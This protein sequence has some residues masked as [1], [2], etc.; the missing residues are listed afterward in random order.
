MK[1]PPLLFN[2]YDIFAIIE[3]QKKALNKAIAGAPAPASGTPDDD[4]VN[5]FV[6]Q[7]TIAVPTL[8]PDQ[9]SLEQ[10]EVDVD[11][12]RD[13][14]RYFSDPSRPFYVKG[15][16][17]SVHVPFT[18]EEALFDTRPSTFSLSP[19]RGEVQDGELILTYIFPNDSPPPNLR[20]QMDADLAGVNKY[21]D[22][23]RNSASTLEAELVPIARA[24]WQKRKGE[25]STRDNVIAKLGVPARRVDAPNQT[26]Q[27]PITRPAETVRN[28]S[29]A[30]KKW[31]V[32]ISHATEDKEAIAKPLADALVSAGLEV[33][34][35]EYALT[36]GDSLR[37]KIDEGLAKSEFGIVILSEAFFSKHWPQQELNG[38][39]AREN[40]GGKVILPVWHNISRN[41][42]LAYSPPLADKL[43]V[44]TSMGLEHVI[45][46]L[47]SAM[48]KK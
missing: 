47:L 43:G 28:A 34:Y 3:N 7:F 6:A 24:A 38:L 9:M 39:A 18:G 12:S 26:P 29:S 36:V 14:R 33:W 1:L 44:P 30:G 15:T 4:I 40:G 13:S 2:K 27:A 11:V 17:L 31:N 46:A 42:V 20:G 16:Q 8:H 48:R 41:D 22:H 25:F 21:L 10:E 37:Q 23:L 45:A 5:R 32:F 19:P 35:D